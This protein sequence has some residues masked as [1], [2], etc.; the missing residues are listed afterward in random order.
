MSTLP[1]DAVATRPVVGYMRVG[2]RL[3]RCTS[4]S[5]IRSQY[6]V[7]AETSVRATVAQ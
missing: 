2:L 4:S 7:V 1:D 3:L 6:V 5:R